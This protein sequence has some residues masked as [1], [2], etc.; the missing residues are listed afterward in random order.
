[1][2]TGLAVASIASMAYGGYSAHEQSRKANKARDRA[3]TSRNLQQQELKKQQIA[4]DK[5]RTAEEASNIE[6]TNRMGTAGGL[7]PI[8]SGVLGGNKRGLGV[9]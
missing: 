5:R 1:M 7:S 9:I 3:D 2:A 6:R 4:V 8:Q